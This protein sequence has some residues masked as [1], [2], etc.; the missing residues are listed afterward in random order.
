[1]TGNSLSYQFKTAN[2]LIK[3]IAINVLVFLAVMLLSFFMQTEASSLTRWFVLPDAIGEI[4]LQPWSFITYSFL[5]F[6]FGHIFWNMVVLY[7]FGKIVLNLFNERRFLT[8]YLLGAIFGGLLY[9]AAYNF[10]S[11]FAETAAYLI[12]ASASVRAIM[13]FIAAYSP[14]TEIRIFIISVKLWHIG[15]LVLVM[16]LVQLASGNNAGGMLAHLGGALFGYVYA[17]QLIKGRDIG[18]WFEK[19]MDGVAGMFKTRKQKPFK[20]VHRNKATQSKDKRSSS[21]VNE[22][23]SDHQKKIDAILDKIGKSGYESLTKGE[24]DFLF[25]SGE[26]N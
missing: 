20:K 26:N 24:K 23:K 16:D 13:I 10:F 2:I 4:L 18:L 8:I 19:I 9:V 21:K 5:H 17:R 6:G 7:M 22:S 25:K 1:M 15:V 12:G 3:I 11:V 14:N